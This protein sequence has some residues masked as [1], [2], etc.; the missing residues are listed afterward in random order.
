MLQQLHD[1][2]SAHAHYLTLCVYSDCDLQVVQYVDGDDIDGL[3]EMYDDDADDDFKAP[4][5]SAAARKRLE[6]ML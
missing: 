3:G 1:V 6:P 4:G 2:V 5:T